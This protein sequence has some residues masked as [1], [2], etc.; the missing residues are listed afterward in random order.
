MLSF[1]TSQL[2]TGNFK[3]HSGQ[4]CHEFGNLHGLIP[5]SYLT[6]QQGWGGGGG[7]EKEEQMGIEKQRR[8]EKKRQ[9]PHK[10]ISFGFSLI[11][12][13]PDPSAPPH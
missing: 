9:G 8:E 2:N 11:P 10:P 4:Q 5:R 13:K 6:G 12:K 7:K 1:L 3:W